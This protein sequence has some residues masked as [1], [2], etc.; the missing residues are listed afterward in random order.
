MQ[1]GD[2]IAIGV[3]AIIVVAVIV[4]IVRQKKNGVKCI[5]CPYGKNCKKCSCDGALNNNP[6]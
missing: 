6:Q 3:I 2:Y 5:G 1:L 4:F